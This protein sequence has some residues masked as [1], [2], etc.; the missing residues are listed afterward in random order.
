ME[1]LATVPGGIFQFEIGVQSTLPQTLNHVGRNASLQRLADNVRFLI[2]Q[3]DIHLHL[4]LIAGLPGENFEQFLSSI[5]WV[6]D[7][8]GNHLQIEPVKLL[9]GA[10]LRNEAE[11]WGIVFDPN[12]PYT[13]LRSGA[14]S[15]HDLERLRGIGRLFD[16][17]VNSE[18][19]NFLLTGLIAHFG[20]I[21]LVLNDLDLYWREHGL[22]RQSRSLRDLYLTI[23]G[24]LCARFGGCSLKG[25]RELLGRDFA[26]HERVVSGTAPAFFDVVLTAEEQETVRS[27]VK[28]EISQL[29]RSGKIQYF[30]SAFHHLPGFC[31]RKILIFLYVPGASAGYHV[32]ELM[33]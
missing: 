6:H 17:L 2:E 22:Y 27:K 19:F 12:P 4:D 25:F 21:S 29:Q 10:P 31:G 3:T 15:F 24:Y 14:M 23:D 32:R 9:P 20:R 13:I 33:L 7:L 26:H 16:L 18:R 11:Q 1:L 30:A 8:G 5:D 28:G